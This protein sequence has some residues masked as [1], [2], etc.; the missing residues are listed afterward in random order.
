MRLL[1]ADFRPAQGAK[2][3]PERVTKVYAICPINE[4]GIVA[5]ITNPLANQRLRM[6]C[7]RL[8]EAKVDL[9]EKYF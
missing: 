2:G 1:M 3:K 6:D 8:K 5:K 9:E 4:N 7:A